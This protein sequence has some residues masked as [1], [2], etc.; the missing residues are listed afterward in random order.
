MVY[1]A[2]SK[3]VVGIDFEQ[4]SGTN[5]D[6]I[7]PKALLKSRDL[8]DVNQLANLTVLSEAD[9]KSKGKKTLVEW[10]REFDEDTLKAHCERHAIP[11]DKSLWVPERF[12]DFI[13]ARKKLIVSSTPLGRLL[14][15]QIPDADSDGAEA[16][17][18]ADEVE[19]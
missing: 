4:M 18:S 11:F 6:H 19:A 16:E 2:L 5:I 10:L 15:D 1:F 8:K 9:N 7:I 3:V 14:R 13:A 17:D 12:D